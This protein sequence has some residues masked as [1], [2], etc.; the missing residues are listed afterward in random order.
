MAP[1]DVLLKLLIVVVVVAILRSS[2][3]FQSM[4]RELD[5]SAISVLK[6]V[7]SA[8]EESGFPPEIIPL[9]MLLTALTFMFSMAVTGGA[10]R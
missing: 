3:R 1:M 2:D 7:M 5:D 8:A 9:L 4:S 6:R 10:G